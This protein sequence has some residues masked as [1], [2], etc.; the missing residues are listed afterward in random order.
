MENNQVSLH[1]V[2]QASPEKVYRAFADP[3]AIASWYPPYGFL[4]QVHEMD[5][6]T[7][8]HFSMSFVNFTTGT[9]Q[10]F[11]GVFEEIRPN[12]LIRYTDHFDDPAL[13]G[14]MTSTVRLNAVSAGTELSIEQTGIP[15]Y[16]P[17]DMCYLGWQE[18][19]DKLKRLV[20]PNIPDM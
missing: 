8:G 7:G 5:F 11:S 1:R 16:I 6:T 10:A 15:D 14:E 3:L 9:G 20:E 17:A 12:E 19:L 18:C 13:P 2:L 4:C